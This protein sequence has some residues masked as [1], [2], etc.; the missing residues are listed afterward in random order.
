MLQRCSYRTVSY[1]HLDVYKRQ[2]HLIAEELAK[3]GFPAIVGPDLSSRS[4]I[5]VQNMA[6]KTCLL[7]TSDRARTQFKL[8]ADMESKWDE[9]MSIAEKYL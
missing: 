2:G 4:K 8:V 7:Y 9:M 5:E 6:F 3:E 1:T